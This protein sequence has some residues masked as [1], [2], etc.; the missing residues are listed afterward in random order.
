MSTLELK[1]VSLSEPSLNINRDLSLLEFQRRVLNEAKDEDI[2]LLE[3]QWLPYKVDAHEEIG[4][5]NKT[6]S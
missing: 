6:A 4:F 1:P 5:E 2:P 3:L